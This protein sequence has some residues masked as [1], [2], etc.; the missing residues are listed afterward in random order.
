MKR[1]HTLTSLAALKEKLDLTEAELSFDEEDQSL[2]P[3]KIPSSFFD[4][5]D[6][7]DPADPIRRQVVPTLFE[8]AQEESLDPLAEEEH[9]VTTR[10]IHRYS[11]RVA[12]LTTDVCFIHCRHCFRRRFT[13]TF[14]GA[15]SEK[16]IEEAA[17]YVG[18]HPEVKEIL[19]TGGDV[20]TLSDE[21]LEAMIRAF[22][23]KRS[24]LIIRICT[25]A[26]AAFPE[27]VT[28]AL[29]ELLRR[30]ESAP[31]FVMTQFNHPRELTKAALMATNRFIDNGIPAFNQTVL[32]NGVNDDADTLE[33]LCNTL[34]ANRIKPYYLFQGDLVRGTAHLRVSVEKGLELE[35]ELRRRLSG[36]AMPLYALDLPEGGGKV[37]LVNSYLEGEKNGALIFRTP[38][39][40]RRTYPLT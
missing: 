12:F 23:S 32:L 27:R 19:F 33:E 29:I 14:Q 34:L 31:F 9:A 13:G 18:N 6:S 25:R 10:L 26:C 30:Y 20:L 7:D 3:V 40:E 2:L 8:H 17:T 1:D 16:E 24:D 4:L 39:G 15:A 35:A 38:D 21:R 36:L 5:I 28:P 37:P 22:R 11:N